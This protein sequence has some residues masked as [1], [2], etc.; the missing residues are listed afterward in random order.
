VNLLNVRNY[1]SEEDDTDESTPNNSVTLYSN[2]QVI[3][4]NCISNS[5]DIEIY[6]KQFFDD[7]KH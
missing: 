4:P 7:K 2:K 6:F 3:L 5:F 1:E